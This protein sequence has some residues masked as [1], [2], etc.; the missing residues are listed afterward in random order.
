MS[1]VMLLDLGYAEEELATVDSADLEV[2]TFRDL[3][4]KKM[5]RDAAA[6]APRQRAVDAEELSP[7]LERGWRVVT[8]VNRHRVVV[9]PPAA[10][11]QH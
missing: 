5:G 11:H 3:G 6:D 4:T 8:A 7:Y 9:D 1:R 10:S 2:A